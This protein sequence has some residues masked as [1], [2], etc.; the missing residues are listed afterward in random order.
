[1]SLASALAI[2]L[3]VWGPL[4][5]TRDA[6]TIG[7]TLIAAAREAPLPWLGEE[8]TVAILAEYTKDESGV[9]A[10]PIPWVGKDGLPVDSLAH[11]YL[12][13]HG[14]AGEGDLMTQARAW[15]A[16]ARYGAIA[17][18]DAP[19]APLTGACRSRKARLLV[20]RRMKAAQRAVDSVL[21]NTP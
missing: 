14:P 4:A 13:I 5:K 9:N 17:C 15:L 7:A 20:D 8:M 12:Q 2:V 6:S 10:H 16:L 3:A 19:L 18:P 21:S 11:G 1:M